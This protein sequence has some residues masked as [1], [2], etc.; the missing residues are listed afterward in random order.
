[1]SNPTT[2]QSTEQ[3]TEKFIEQILEA[4]GFER[5]YWI[6]H[7]QAAMEMALTKV[8]EITGT[9]SDQ[10]IEGRK[11]G[12]EA[13]R[14]Y[15]QDRQPAE[16]TAE[17][18]KQCPS[19]RRKYSQEAWPKSACA[20]GICPALNI[21]EQA[22]EHT[23]TGNCW[24]GDRRG[25]R[26]C[27][28]H[29]PRRRGDCPECPSCPACSKEAVAQPNDDGTMGER[30]P[31]DVEHMIQRAV[32]QPAE[33]PKP[34]QSRVD[35]WLLACFGELIARDK[36]ERNHRFLEE[37]LEVVQACGC[38]QSEAN[39]LVA[40]VYGRPTGEA[41]Q[42]V[43]GAIVTLVA[44]CLARDIDFMEAGETELQR[45][46]TKV[47]QI[48]EKQAAKPKHG[49]LPVA[50]Q[51]APRCVC[52]SLPDDVYV[53]C[54]VHPEARPA[55]DA[56]GQSYQQPAPVAEGDWQDVQ[57]GCLCHP[58]AEGE[59]RK[60]QR[61]TATDL[62]LLMDN[63]DSVWLEQRIAGVTSPTR[64][65]TMTAAL[66]LLGGISPIM[67][68][69]KEGEAALSSPQ[70]TI[71]I[72][73][74]HAHGGTTEWALIANDC[75]VY[76]TDTSHPRCDKWPLFIEEAELIAYAL[77]HRHPSIDPA[78]LSV[79]KCQLIL[80]QMRWDQ[81]TVGPELIY[82][83]IDHQGRHGTVIPL[84]VAQIICAFYVSRGLVGVE[85]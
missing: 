16:P 3:I 29:L 20:K 26:Y 46:W 77:E 78:S 30:Q 22:P 79:D 85:K 54:P 18:A 80:E 11:A 84:K 15:D 27:T 19:C 56:F 48:R 36:T 24:T 51:P 6:N 52:S 58:A 68:T 67:I 83:N 12:I 33:S 13:M 57:D 10:W 75:Q 2:K 25:L 21:A 34:F 43:G 23:R 72:L 82:L 74:R 61:H 66:K 40:Y 37:A 28:Q 5:S 63:A 70:Q 65:R 31:G 32:G 44:L 35:D 69:G 76:T 4:L 17:Q 47:E 53:D 38:T 1:M 8:R 42:E 73:N 49:P 45:I 7:P 59:E 50:E 64:R 39:Q 60:A 71:E 81:E 9:G 41:N 14:Q 62:A 55:N